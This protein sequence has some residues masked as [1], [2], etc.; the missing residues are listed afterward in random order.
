MKRMKNQQIFITSEEMKAATV[1]YLQVSN[2]HVCLIS[3]IQ[4]YSRVESLPIFQ[5]QDVSVY[6]KTHDDGWDVQVSVSNGRQRGFRSR[7]PVFFCVCEKN[8]TLQRHLLR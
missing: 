6:L 3:Q 7:G 5:C 2:D 4:D 8:S 1:Q